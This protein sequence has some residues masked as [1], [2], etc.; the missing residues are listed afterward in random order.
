MRCAHELVKLRPPP[1]A[2]SMPS[3]F[4][5]TSFRLQS[6][7]GT[8]KTDIRHSLAL[9]DYDTPAYELKRPLPAA[10]DVLSHSDLS[11]L[12]SIFDNGLELPSSAVVA[13]QLVQQL[14]HVLRQVSDYMHVSFRS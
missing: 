11:V 14:V 4:Y 8:L 7:C 10:I 9:G 5:N 6:D 2:T 1:P 13:S 12:L 3:L